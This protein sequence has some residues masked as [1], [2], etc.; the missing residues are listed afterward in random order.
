MDQRLTEIKIQGYG[1][2][3]LVM[4]VEILAA[5]MSRTGYQVQSFSQYGTKRRGEE[6]NLFN[7][8]LSYKF[9]ANQIFS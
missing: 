3:G 1:G 7:P 9:G 8:D 2:Q 4:A 6:M 5:I